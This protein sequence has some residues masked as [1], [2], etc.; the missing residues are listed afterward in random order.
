MRLALVVAIVAAAIVYVAIE[1]YPPTP[2]AGEY[3]YY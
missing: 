2:G 3:Y 1:V